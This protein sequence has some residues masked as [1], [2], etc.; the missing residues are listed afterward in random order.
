MA[1]TSNPVFS[2]SARA[3]AA[4]YLSGDR[5]FVPQWAATEA[6][7]SAFLRVNAPA[8]NL[9][10]DSH[11][12]DSD[13]L[14]DLAPHVQRAATPLL[15]VPS[16]L[17]LFPGTFKTLPQVPPY[18][19]RLGEDAL[20]GEALFDSLDSP[21]WAPN[22]TFGSFT[23]DNKLAKSLAEGLW[24]H[25]RSADPEDR[26]AEIE[27]RL[28]LGS[29]FVYSSGTAEGFATRL[30]GYSKSEAAISKAV[31]TH[32]G[33]SLSAITRRIMTKRLRSRPVFHQFQ[34]GYSVLSS[35]ETNPTSGAGP[36]YGNVH[37]KRD[38][39]DKIEAAIDLLHDQWSQGTVVDFL[40]RHP[41][42][43]V[44]ECKNKTDLYEVDKLK[45][46]T[47]P[48]YHFNAHFAFLYSFLCQ[49]WTEGMEVCTK[50]RSLDTWNAYGHSW[51]NKGAE[52]IVHLA[53]KAG[54]VPRSK[55]WVALY[56]DDSLYSFPQTQKSGGVERKGVEIIGPDVSQMDSTVSHTVIC[57]VIDVIREAYEK[58]CGPSGFI[59]WVCEM[60]KYDA[61]HPRVGCHGTTTYQYQGTAGLATGIV[62][63]TLF[64]TV[65]AAIAAELVFKMRESTTE[66]CISTINRAYSACGMTVKPGTEQTQFLPYSDFSEECIKHKRNILNWEGA[67]MS[68]LTVPFLG[69]EISYAR[70][71]QQAWGY[72]PHLTQEGIWRSLLNP[73]GYSPRK[74][75]TQ[76]DRR[77]F[78]TLRGLAL[79]TGGVLA[80]EW[81]AISYVMNRFPD[82]IVTM[83]VQSDD[84]RGEMLPLVGFQEIHF[85][86]SA[87]VPS[88]K[89]VMRLFAHDTQ[90]ETAWIPLLKL[91]EGST[92]VPFVPPR[93]VEVDV[94]KVALWTDDQLPVQPLDP[95]PSSM[96]PPNQKTPRALTIKA[97]P[98]DTSQEW[99][100]T[101]DTAFM[102]PAITLEYLAALVNKNKRV[103]LKEALKWGV[104]FDGDL[105]CRPHFSPQATFLPP[106]RFARRY[107]DLVDLLKERADVRV[108]TVAPPEAV[109][110]VATD[111]AL[112]LEGDPDF[113]ATLD[114]SLQPR[115]EVPDWLLV[116][117]KR[118]PRPYRFLNPTSLKLKWT[119]LQVTGGQT[120]FDI[121]QTWKTLFEASGLKLDAKKEPYVV[122]GITRVRVTYT[123]GAF[124]CAVDAQD[125]VSS[126]RVLFA[127]LTL[128]YWNYLAEAPI[129][130]AI[131]KHEANRKNKQKTQAQAYHAP[132]PE[133][134][135]SDGEPVLQ[136]SCGP[137]PG[138]GGTYQCLP[139]PSRSS[140]DPSGEN[141]PD[142]LQVRSE[143]R[144]SGLLP[145]SGLQ[146]LGGFSGASVPISGE[147]DTPSLRSRNGVPR[148]EFPRNPLP[149]QKQG[150]VER[151]ENSDQEQSRGVQPGRRR[152]GN[153]G[154]SNR[155]LLRQSGLRSNRARY[156]NSYDSLPILERASV[157]ANRG[158]SSEH[159]LRHE[160]ILSR[161]GG[162]VLGGLNERNGPSVQQRQSEEAVPTPPPRSRRGRKAASV[163]GQSG[164]LH[165]QLPKHDYRKVK[166]D[167][168]L[169]LREVACEPLPREQ[170][171][172]PPSNVGQHRG[173]NGHYL[174]Q[175]ARQAA[176]SARYPLPDNVHTTRGPVRVSNR[177]TSPADP[178][179][180]IYSPR[181]LGAVDSTGV[182]R[183]KGK[184][185]SRSR[186]RVPSS[187][188]G[189]DPDYSPCVQ[190]GSAGPQ[191]T[192]KGPHVLCKPWSRRDSPTCL[193]CR[194]RFT[195]VSN[196]DVLCQRCLSGGPPPIVSGGQQPR[197]PTPARVQ[198]Q[199]NHRRTRSDASVQ[200][201][202]STEWRAD[203]SGGERY[204]DRRRRK[205]AQGGNQRKRPGEERRPRPEPTQS[206]R[207]GPDT[208][209]RTDGG[210]PIRVRTRV[211]ESSVAVPG[212]PAERVRQR[213]LPV[214]RRRREGS[215]VRPEPRIEEG[216]MPPQF[217]QPDSDD[218]RGPP[219]RA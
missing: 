217:Y 154:E 218:D 181:N 219:C 113:L 148:Q 34:D 6:R 59:Q 163:A 125:S 193:F 11:R 200:R 62:G 117:A 17:S 120:R 28:S 216:E 159:L 49:P 25:F 171:R 126:E 4:D 8:F 116:E 92:E 109:E 18:R 35:V 162:Q 40:E 177:T 108:S 86:D 194:S 83:P 85:P 42:W 16:G 38:V 71:D 134:S 186:P 60:W 215:P 43:Y 133:G 88:P 23:P 207:R 47:R 63:T 115:G 82:E 122:G 170:R 65:Q 203:A 91:R 33:E 50:T 199:P 110:T 137:D 139:E 46:K 121:R 15:S 187:R 10:G 51:A 143:S 48:Y 201:R 76:S 54:K 185:R 157:P 152:D 208:R 26:F 202:P 78:D 204:T 211:F 140:R 189:P 9:S 95:E 29:A 191:C 100:R 105:L 66:A 155:W 52:S 96:G 151:T 14:R 107:Q 19:A 56:G 31:K 129:L 195:P 173:V 182:Y 156:P 94:Q 136:R 79:C 192:R 188:R 112:P 118:Q 37:Q 205:R 102:G 206:D 111:Y 20:P 197:A 123:C 138:E 147:S 45:K 73:K 3:T 97:E 131:R 69:M 21:F 57:T 12:L 90:S 80:P 114:R 119:R 98:S 213:R 153:S 198:R 75:R 68:V 36:L 81:D 179:A 27:S 166:G 175:R 24:D 44:A 158:A 142:I 167:F 1:A 146:Q 150:V 165:D 77:V 84:G 2:A 74:S 39:M 93:P 127:A 32:F 183:R 30:Y 101:L 132:Q 164:Q 172:L 53:L 190:R 212:F 67:S 209:P 124:E 214:G 55:G 180:S 41:L 210:R 184:S 70:T 178:D 5:R 144:P 161:P 89:W 130:I 104:W 149:C 160:T 22:R 135:R 58:Q 72:V 64:D 128:L 87:G 103:C 176:P 13:V 7:R 61:C 145:F 174:G 106:A 169:D 141:V 99:I 196:A 168:V